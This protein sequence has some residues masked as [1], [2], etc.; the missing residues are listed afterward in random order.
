MKIVKALEFN[1][2]DVAAIAHFRAHIF[3][4]MCDILAHHCEL[5]PFN[6]ACTNIEE[7]LDKAITDKQ[8]FVP[9]REE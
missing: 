6:E 2:E 7:F 8:W 3:H 9:E 4:P 1:K 5:C